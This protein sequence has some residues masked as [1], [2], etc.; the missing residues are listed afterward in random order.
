M[1]ETHHPVVSREPQ[2]QLGDRRQTERVMISTRQHTTPCRRAQRRRLE[3]RV[4]K[5]GLGQPIQR[6]RLDQPTERRH[7]TEP[8]IV[9]HEH[10]HVRSTRLRTVRRRPRRRRLLHRLPDPTRKGL[11]LCVFHQL[12]LIGHGRSPL[13]TS[14]GSDKKLLRE[15]RHPEG[16]TRVISVRITRMRWLVDGLRSSTFARQPAWWSRP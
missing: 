1:F 5:T 16:F 10:H 9:E 2:R 7:L 6:R 8:D 15:T 11:A 4:A 13:A 3:I 14:V 12:A